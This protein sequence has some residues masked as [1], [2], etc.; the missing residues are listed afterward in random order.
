LLTLPHDDRLQWLLE[1]SL[2]RGNRLLLSGMDVLHHR[3]PYHH[4]P[5]KAGTGSPRARA[6]AWSI[7]RLVPRHCSGNHLFAMAHFVCV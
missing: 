6:Q 5:D 4:R 3:G 7:D 1:G 2:H